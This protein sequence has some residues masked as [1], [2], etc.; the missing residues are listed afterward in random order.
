[1][2][3]V[4]HEAAQRGETSD[5]ATQPVMPVPWERGATRHVALT[6]VLVG[7]NAAVF[8]G[9]ILAGMSL[10][11]PSTQQLI[12]WGANW[13]PLTLGGQPWRL[14]TCIF[15]HA[16]ILHIGFNM[17]CLWDLGALCESLYG[18]WTFGAVYFISG[19]GASITSVAWNPG[20]VSV[21]ASGA[22]FGVAAR[23]R[24]PEP[25]GEGSVQRPPV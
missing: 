14:L 15:L 12:R 17:W 18:P 24:R 22:I 4:R 2:W 16:G 5:D 11:D 25:R 13:G 8:L 19:V 10:T 1:V 9:M 20:G 6:Q 7:I 23:A 3:C 21:G